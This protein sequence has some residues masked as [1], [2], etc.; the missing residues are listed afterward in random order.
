MG[1][2]TVLGVTLSRDLRSCMQ[3]K[4]FLLTCYDTLTTEFITII[5]ATALIDLFG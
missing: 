3:L 1:M 2:L 5:Y 4:F